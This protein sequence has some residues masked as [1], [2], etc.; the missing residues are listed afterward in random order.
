MSDVRSERADS[1]RFSRQR[2]WHISRGGGLPE[3]R[4]SSRHSD[5][6]RPGTQRQAAEEIGQTGKPSKNICL[7]SLRRTPRP[8]PK[9]PS[10]ADLEGLR[11]WLRERKVSHV[12]MD[13]TGVFW[14][15]VWNVLEHRE[16]KSALTLINPQHLHALPG[17]KTDRKFVA[18][19]HPNTRQG[20]YQ[21]LSTGDG[22]SR[23]TP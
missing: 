11:D 4:R 14:I 5:G 23:T 16:T 8:S 20:L 21:T 3:A 19:V 10:P 13:S 17:H 6:G 1:K 9:F 22:E 7:I 12:A 2:K 18:L 15:P